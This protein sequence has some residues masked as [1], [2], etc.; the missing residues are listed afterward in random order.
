MIKWQNSIVT[1]K[2][3]IKDSLILHGFTEQL[4]YAKVCYKC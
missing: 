3:Q 2:D 4:I 1:N